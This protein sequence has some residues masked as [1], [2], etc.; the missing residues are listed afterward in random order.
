MSLPI[1]HSAKEIRV[2]SF[3]PSIGSSPVAAQFAAPWRGRIT[4]IGCVTG[5]SITTS[6]CTITLSING[7]NVNGGVG[8][9]GLPTF[10]NISVLVAGAA[11]GQLFSWTRAD[12]SGGPGIGA[13]DGFVNEDDVI[14]LTPSNAS[15]A[16]IPAY[17][18]VNVAKA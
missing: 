7:T 1:P 18:F 8:A 14:T 16:N 10:A 13:V 5:G 17:L 6:N 9:G 3:S 2:E 11:A 12:N 4:K 15:G